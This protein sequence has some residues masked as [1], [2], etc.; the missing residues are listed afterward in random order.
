MICVMLFL[1]DGLWS[2]AVSAP[3]RASASS[4][5]EERA[6]LPKCVSERRGGQEER[7][8][9]IVTVQQ[10]AAPPACR[11]ARRGMRDAPGSLVP[12]GPRAAAPAA[13][14]GCPHLPRRGLSRAR[15]RLPAFTCLDA[16]GQRRLGQRLPGAGQQ[17]SPQQP[18]VAFL[19][20]LGGHRLRGREVQEGVP[21]LGSLGHAPQRRRLCPG[22]A[23]AAPMGSGRGRE[24]ADGAGA[25]AA[26]WGS[27]GRRLRRGPG[28]CHRG[29]RW[30]R[31]SAAVKGRRGGAG[32]AAG[33]RCALRRRPGR[34]HGSPAGRD[35]PPAQ[36]APPRTG[37][38][39]GCRAAAGRSLRPCLRLPSRRGARSGQKGTGH[40]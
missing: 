36:G 24:R 33:D 16:G 9:G 6:S 31:P 25:A 3:S 39:G 18:R 20:R 8:K 2:A 4:S 21:L 23:R 7:P 12:A 5:S 35:G 37:P 32:A 38:G 15:C 34:R 28:L 11:P 10:H 30:C 22:V 14:P 40:G 27:G 26:A 13:C 1:E 17:A 19:L 29:R